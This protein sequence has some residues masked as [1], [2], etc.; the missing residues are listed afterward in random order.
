MKIKVFALVLMFIS[1]GAEII[2]NY[3]L[4]R[5]SCLFNYFMNKK[6]SLFFFLSLNLFYT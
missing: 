1:H 5:T 6:F 3:V 4:K 2:P